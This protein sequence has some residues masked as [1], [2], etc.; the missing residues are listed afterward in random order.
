MIGFISTL[1]FADQIF[2]ATSPAPFVCALDLL[3]VIISI[4]ENQELLCILKAIASS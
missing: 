1:K 4:I 2:S 3:E